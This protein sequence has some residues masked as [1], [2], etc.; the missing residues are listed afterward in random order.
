MCMSV[1][2]Y[3]YMSVCIYI[4]VCVCVCVCVC[5]YV[6]IYVYMLYCHLQHHNAT[7]ITTQADFFINI[8]V[9]LT[10][11]VRVRKGCSRFL[12]E[13]ELETEQKLQYSDL[14]SYGR[15]RC[16]FLV[17]QGCS[18]GGPETHC[19]VMALFTASYQ[20]L[21]WTPTHQG[22]WPLWPDVAFPTTSHL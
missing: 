22:L 9:P 8:C 18:T 19:W 5:I 21:L 16:V 6:Y 10:L 2:I 3:M 20:H 17:L 13:R 12:C 7:L 4:C 14:F 11:F 15:Q 1:N